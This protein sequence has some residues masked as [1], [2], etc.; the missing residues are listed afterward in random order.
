MFAAK[1][2]VVMVPSRREGT[3]TQDVSHVKIQLMRVMSAMVRA[4]RMTPI[5]MSMARCW[6]VIV[7]GLPV[8]GQVV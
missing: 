4:A 3:I 1:G 2:A 8:R 7:L 5:P 6:K